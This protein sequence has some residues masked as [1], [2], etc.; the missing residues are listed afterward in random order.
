VILK[1]WTAVG[2]RGIFGAEVY[3]ALFVEGHSRHEAAIF[4]VKVEQPPSF[5]DQSKNLRKMDGSRETF[6]KSG[7][8]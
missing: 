6:R 5:S 1:V 7:S 8:L 3:A 4:G 2:A